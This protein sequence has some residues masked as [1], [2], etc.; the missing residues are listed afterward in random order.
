M[1]VAIKKWGNSLH[2]RENQ[3]LNIEIE[4]S[5]ILIKPITRE[6]ESLLAQITPKNIHNEISFGAAEGKEIW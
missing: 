4:N 1:Q 5:N 2:L 3:S 6:L